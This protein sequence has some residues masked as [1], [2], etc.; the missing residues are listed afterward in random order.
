MPTLRYAVLHHVEVEEPH[1]DLLFETQPGSM[2]AA[3]RVAEWPPSKGQA[4]KRLKDHRRLYLT[5]EGVIPGGDRGRVDRVAD[6]EIAV[7]GGAEGWRL[8]HADGRPMLRVEPDQRDPSGQ[9]W[10]MMVAG[11][12][13]FD[14]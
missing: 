1:Y 4:A 14:R 8:N 9:L 12:E 7:T 6:G 5:Y 13:G 10:W 11:E 2:L 3:F